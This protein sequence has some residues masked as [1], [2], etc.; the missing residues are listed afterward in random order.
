MGGLARKAT[1]IDES[2]SNGESL[3]LVDAGDL[4]FHKSALYEGKDNI[5]GAKIRANII[6]D[7]YNEMG[8]HAFTPGSKDFA[9]GIEYLRKME[10][11]S[12]F[13]YISCNLF[14]SFTSK[15]LFNSYAIEEINGYRIGYIGAASSFNKDS[16]LVKEPIDLIV[17]TSEKIKNKTDFIILLFNGTDSDIKRLQK[18][19]PSIDLILRSRG[20]SRTS[21]NGGKG[22]IPVYS[23]GSKG[24]YVNK[25][26]VNINVDSEAL[27]DLDLERKN[28]RLSKKHLKNKK[29]GDSNAN[30]D[31]LY[32]DNQK[33]LK[34]IEYH[35]NVIEAS[36]AKIDNANNSIE[37]TKIA[38]NTKVA[39]KPEILLIVDTGMATI[40]EGPPRIDH[41][42][43]NHKHH[44]HNH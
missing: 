23:S 19:D 8:Y 2:I 37:T 25:I 22:E 26:D 9:L 40:P 7:S 28:I 41:S 27:V 31:E 33:I 3:V 36:N 24:K 5:D 13:D 16:V 1:I 38:L 35:R 18:K 10:A 30:L 14:N 4:L 39:S 32:K 15:Q 20:S 34:D 6:V 43:H 17:S 11:K 42:G 44:N 29:K 12:N 21:E